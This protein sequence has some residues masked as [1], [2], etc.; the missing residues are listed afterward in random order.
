MLL[1]LGVTT[2]EDLYERVTVL[3][4]KNHWFTSF[5]PVL[6]VGLVFLKWAIS[7]ELTCFYLCVE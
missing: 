4:V 3:G 6:L 1:C 7:W 2:H 5:H